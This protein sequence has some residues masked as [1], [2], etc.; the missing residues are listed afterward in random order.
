[1]SQASSFL[2]SYNGIFDLAGKSDYS[3]YASNWP[4]SHPLLKNRP[5]AKG[6]KV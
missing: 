4:R 3:D 1:M 6:P 5:Q 2:V